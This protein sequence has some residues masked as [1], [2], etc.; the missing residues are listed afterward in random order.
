[1]RKRRVWWLSRVSWREIL[2]AGAWGRG[3]EREIGEPFGSEKAI[4][5]VVVDVLVF[6]RV[7]YRVEGGEVFRY[8]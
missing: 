6:V 2:T 3:K 8:N 5:G 7:G 4:L 1:V